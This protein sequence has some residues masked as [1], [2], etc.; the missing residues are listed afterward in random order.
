[1]LGLWLDQIK[2]AARITRACFIKGLHR[3]IFLTSAFPLNFSKPSGLLLLIFGLGFVAARVIRIFAVRRI[4]LQGFKK[5]DNPFNAGRCSN[6]V[7]SIAHTVSS[8]GTTGKS[9][10]PCGCGRARHMDGCRS[11]DKIVFRSSATEKLLE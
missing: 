9:A 11:M 1:M 10:M 5:P 4:H 8:S 6:I 2:I 3:K 7:L